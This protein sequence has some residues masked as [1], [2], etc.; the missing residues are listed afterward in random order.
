[1]FLL[2]NLLCSILITGCTPRRGLCSEPNNKCCSG[3][4]KNNSCKG[5]ARELAKPWEVAKSQGPP[6]FASPK[7]QERW[8]ELVAEGMR[9]NEAI[10]QIA[11]EECPTGNP[12]ACSKDWLAQT[13]MDIKYCRCYVE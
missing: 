10:H 4:C 3:N 9:G 7:A 6:S 12:V 11:I 8:T 5:D 1:M 13:G 2:S